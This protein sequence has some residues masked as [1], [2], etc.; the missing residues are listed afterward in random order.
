MRESAQLFR[1]W[2]VEYILSSTGGEGY[3]VDRAC[4]RVSNRLLSN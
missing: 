3:T 2:E 4:K 1:V